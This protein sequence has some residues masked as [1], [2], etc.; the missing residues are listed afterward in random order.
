MNKIEELKEILK[1]VKLED[2][3]YSL[4]SDF[5]KEKGADRALREINRRIK[6]VLQHTHYI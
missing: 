2:I 5:Y 3:G 6:L 1:E 4:P